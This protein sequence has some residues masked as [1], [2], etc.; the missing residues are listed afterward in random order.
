MA[1]RGGIVAGGGWRRRGSGRRGGGA[2]LSASLR[3]LRRATSGAPSPLDCVRAPRL[4]SRA[5]RCPGDFA[6]RGSFVLALE[7]SSERQTRATAT[8]FSLFNPDKL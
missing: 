2:G 7:R 5:V 6:R 8:M 3:G 1:A 4:E